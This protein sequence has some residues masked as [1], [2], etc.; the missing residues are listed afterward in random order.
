MTVK[1]ISKLDTNKKLSKIRQNM[2]MPSN[3]A[4]IEAKNG[5]SGGI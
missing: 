1:K 3:G 2:V 4:K 5:G